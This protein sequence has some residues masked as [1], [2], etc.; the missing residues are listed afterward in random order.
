MKKNTSTFFTIASMAL[1]AFVGCKDKAKE[2]KTTEAETIIEQALTSEKYVVDTEAS[3]IEWQGFKPAGSHNGTIDIENGILET[4]NGSITGGSFL[5]NMNS[6]KDSENDAKLEGHLKS[7]DFFEVEKHPNAAFEITNIEKIEGLTMLSGNLT[8]KDIKNN[9][10]FPVTIS[11]TNDNLTLSSETF[12]I[13]RTKWGIKF[14]SKTF[15][16]N[17]EDNFIND[18]IE[19]KVTVKATK[20]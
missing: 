3:T 12:S 19:L 14:K 10:T 8:L 2:A 18:E 20:L 17:L 9:I 7:G 4:S 13:D 5:I 6:L 16:E 15:I 11:N 1:F